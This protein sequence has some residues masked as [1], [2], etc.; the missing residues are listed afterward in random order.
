MLKFYFLSSTYLG[1]GW[2]IHPLTGALIK[3]PE[4]KVS[5]FRSENLPAKIST[6]LGFCMEPYQLG[7]MLEIV[8][9]V[10]NEHDL[11]LKQ[12]YS[13][14]SYFREKNFFASILYASLR[15]PIYENSIE[16][17]SA[18]SRVFP[19]DQYT[20]ACLQRALTVAKMSIKFKSHGVLLIGAQLP[21]K[22]MHAWIIEDGF[23]PDKTDRRWIN[24]LP[25]L[26]L[27]Y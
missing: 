1:S 26:A 15:R 5:S 7:S 27:A 22:S 17:M 6:A 13:R 20:E 23:Q 8:P 25:L 12:I 16:A 2:A 24:Y 4:S 18:I 14:L 11:A 21:L 19:E 10:S 9:A 3:Y